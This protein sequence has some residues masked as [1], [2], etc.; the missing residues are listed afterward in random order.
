MSRAHVAAVELL[1]QRVPTLRGSTLLDP[2]CGDGQLSLQVLQAERFQRAQLNDL[3]RSAPAATF[4]DAAM[5]ESWRSWVPVDWV[6]SA[7]PRRKAR[8][9]IGRAMERVSLGVAV[10]LPSGFLGVC[11]DWAWC[12][13]AP[14]NRRIWVP[15]ASS[16]TSD[17]RASAASWWLVWERKVIAALAV[18]PRPQPIA[19][20]VARGT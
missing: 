1:L 15:P 11:R 14:P 3:D 8:A 2:C 13:G 6:I 4:L 16:P 19:N 20:Q 9:I 12:G 5:A 17:P 10:L 18:V 7:P